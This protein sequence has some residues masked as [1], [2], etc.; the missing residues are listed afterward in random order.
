MRTLLIGYKGYWGKNILR[1]IKSCPTA[2]LVSAVDINSSPEDR[3]ILGNDVDIRSDL[4]S[5]LIGSDRLDAAI[6][7]TPSETHC[8]LAEQ[9]LNAG[10]SVLLEKPMVLSVEE[11]DRLSQVAYPSNQKVGVD[12]T[13][14][15]DTKVRVIKDVID[16][17]RIGKILSVQSTRANLGLFNN[18]GV[19]WDL[20]PHDIALTDYLFGGSLN[21]ETVVA[22]DNIRSGVTDTVSIFG[23][24][25]DISYGLNL[26][27]LYPK[28][29]R[30]FVIVGTKGMIEYDMLSQEPLIIYDK[31][32][33]YK[34]KKWAHDYTWKSVYNGP[35]GEPLALL[36]SEFSDWVDGRSDSFI[37][38]FESGLSVVET[39][40]EINTYI[41]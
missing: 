16:S 38:D 18:N 14:L 19:V 15:F 35:P 5:A 7:V 28:K 1:N 3:N 27:W 4:A 23:S 17:G 41:Y 22:K 24:Y 12:H 6:I 13:F 29:V 33:E 10:L 25:G 26:S 32:A 8:D 34:D 9:C 2:T 11:T 21:I 30:D 37:S 36:I 20:A 39:I 40:E 31:V